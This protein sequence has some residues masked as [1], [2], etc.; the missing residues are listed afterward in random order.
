MGKAVI[1]RDS[2]KINELW[3]EGLRPW[4]PQGKESPDIALIHVIPGTVSSSSKR[5]HISHL[6]YLQ[7]SDGYS[8]IFINLSLS[9][10]EFGDYWDY[11]GIAQRLQYA[12]EASKAYLYGTKM[13]DEK[14]G[15]T[16]RV[17]FSSIQS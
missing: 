14:I 12:F 9:T 5:N 1:S 11:S 13:H 4:F 6:S 3:T 10:L 8:I 17:G 16:G 2:N 15:D 7:S